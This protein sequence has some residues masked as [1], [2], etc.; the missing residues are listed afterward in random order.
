MKLKR[1][2][3]KLAFIESLKGDNNQ[4]VLKKLATIQRLSQDK[5]SEIRQELASWLVL[6]DNEEI[7]DVLYQMLFD[8][9]GMV[10]LAAVDSICMGRQEK[11]IEKVKTMMGGQ[12][13][14]IRAYA[15]LTM[16]D[17]I[18]NRYGRNEDAVKRYEEIVA[19]YYQVE[20]NERVLIDYYQN[21]FHMDNEKGLEMLG[22]SY[23]HAVDE[24]DAGLVWPL[25]HIFRDIKNSNNE[26]KIDDILNYR[27]EH[28][29]PVQRELAERIINSSLK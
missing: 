15:V 22:K 19:P 16:F 2:K 4:T 28:I 20:K 1:M 23:M 18:T 5:N 27:M 6:F 21:Q 11:T 24:G 14:L 29:L 8:K 12:G 3:D 13:Y 10:R 9:N 26:K 7:E 25:L 17:L